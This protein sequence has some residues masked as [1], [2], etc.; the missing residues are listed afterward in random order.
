MKSEII[1]CPKCHTL[2]LE[3]PQCPKCGW[4]RPT[5]PPGEDKRLLWE[6]RYMER[7]SSGLV[8]AQG[9]LFFL[10]GRGRLHALDAE[11]MEEAWDQLVALGDWRIHERVAVNDALV[12]LGA[13]DETPLPEA[14]KA[15]LALD[16]RTG[17]ERWR[18]PLHERH[19]SDPLIA[20]DKIF[21]ATS[22][23]QGVALRL[24]DGEHL[25]EQPIQGIYMASPAA[26]EDLVYFG[27]NQGALTALRST[28]PASL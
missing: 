28:T 21:V 22:A 25:W 11:R 7:I 27:G 19:I 20:N 10:D 2:L 3:A 15:V 1:F 23:S 16:I 12:I 9:L 5:R 4:K 18:R 13:T 24:A 17:K 8:W 14:D 6:T 26:Y